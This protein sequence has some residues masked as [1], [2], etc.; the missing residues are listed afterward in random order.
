[1]ADDATPE[2][3]TKH[4]SRSVGDLTARLTQLITSKGMKVFD[5]IDQREE[6]RLV[7]LDLRETILVIFGSPTAGTPVMAAAPL[8]ALDLPLKVLLWDDGTGTSLSYYAPHAIA[9]RHGL[10]PEL[11]ARISGID[12]LTDAVVAE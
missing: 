10:D 5:V 3:V 4:S 11:E 8:A 6:A 1:M 2:I 9:V 12:G 7:G